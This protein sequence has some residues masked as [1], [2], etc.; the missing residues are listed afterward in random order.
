MP[1][2]AVT[3]KLLQ[4]L[5]KGMSR[6]NKAFDKYQIS[7]LKKLQ[8]SSSEGVTKDLYEECLENINEFYVPIEDTLS[9]GRLI[10]SQS[11]IQL[12][13]LS[14]LSDKISTQI[15]DAKNIVQPYTITEHHLELKNIIKIYQRVVIELNKSGVD[16]VAENPSNEPLV[17]NLC[18]ELQE[19][20]LHLDVGTPYIKK[21]ELIRKK[22][23][24][25]RKR[26]HFLNIA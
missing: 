16:A 17:E 13:K 2:S 23:Q 21:L 3:L 10:A 14:H 7:F 19:V 20:I 9:E 6:Q 11:Q 25:K 12:Q 4:Q 18:D 5:L 22:Y 15:E 24:M 8:N 26:L 1:S